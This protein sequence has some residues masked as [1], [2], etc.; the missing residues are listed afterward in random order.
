LT[1]DADR[2]WAALRRLFEGGRPTAGLLSAASGKAESTLRRRIEK[3]GWRGEAARVGEGTQTRL[4]YL[5]RLYREMDRLSAIEGDFGKAEYDAVNAI[6]RSI[7][8]IE[9]RTTEGANDT[10]EPDEE[11]L[12]A[13]FE[14]IDR[15]IVELASELAGRLGKEDIR[16]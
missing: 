16:Q 9:E 6:T 11:F 15:R 5:A 10:S 4:R 8:K 7:E 13:A 3:E 1:Q 12:A 14:R 2:A